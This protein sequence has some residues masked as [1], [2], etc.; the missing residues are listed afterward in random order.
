MYANVQWRHGPA[1]GKE[2]PS[3]RFKES[4][5]DVRG[6]AVSRLKRQFPPLS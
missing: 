2:A 5:L 1:T 4:Y 6:T 3:Y